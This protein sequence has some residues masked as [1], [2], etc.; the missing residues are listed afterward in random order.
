[1]TKEITNLTLQSLNIS[2]ESYFVLNEDLIIPLYINIADINDYECETISYK[3]DIL[4]QSVRM[5]ITENPFESKLIKYKICEIYDYYFKFIDKRKLFNIDNEEL[6]FF[7]YVEKSGINKYEIFDEAEFNRFRNEV[8][9]YI[10]QVKYKFLI[11]AKELLEYDREFPENYKPKDNDMPQ[12]IKDS[13]IYPLGMTMIQGDIEYPSNIIFPENI[14][15]S[16][17]EHSFREIQLKA[18][19]LHMKNKIEGCLNSYQA[20]KMEQD[21]PKESNTKKH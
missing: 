17:A 18:M 19:F 4:R 10:N 14:G 13:I 11:K 8:T 16:V 5:D 2:L 20:W 12:I 3:V 7:E 15:K 1:M 9:F 21:R 6:N